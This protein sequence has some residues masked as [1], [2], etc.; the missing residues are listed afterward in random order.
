[1]PDGQPVYV[2]F[3]KGAYYEVAKAR[4]Y[5]QNAYNSI[6]STM[7][8]TPEIQSAS[9]AYRGGI[10]FKLDRHPNELLVLIMKTVGGE[11]YVSSDK[12]KLEKIAH[13]YNKNTGIYEDVTPGNLFQGG[14]QVKKPASRKRK[15]PVK[16]AAKKTVVK[17]KTA[18]KKVVKKKA[19]KKK[20]V[21]KKAA[22]KKVVKKKA[23][24]KKVVKKKTAPKK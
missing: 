12:F 8:T 7:V 15:V 19:A 9:F 11:N 18:T 10:N 6:I 13:V 24:K 16:K 1:M 23:A 5:Q 21:K 4:P 2:A 20:V 17:K 3:K 14:A 22:K